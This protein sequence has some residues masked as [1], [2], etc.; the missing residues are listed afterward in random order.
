MIQMEPDSYLSPPSPQR[1]EWFESA[2]RVK[3]PA[4]LR[5]LLASGNGGVPVQRTFESS[6]R[7][8][9]IERFL[10]LLDSPKD[11][12]R[13]GIYDISVVMTQVD[14]R[15]IDDEDLVGMNV[16]PIAAL[17]GGDLLCLDYR[18]GRGPSVAVWSHEESDEF[19]PVLYP[20]AESY[21]EFEGQLR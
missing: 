17:F 16:I 15:L 12:S 7:E 21:S 4:E 8:R 14:E 10:P 5:E 18:K 2:Y 9:L 3:L 6:G 13:H 1:I 11:D 19:E 20:V